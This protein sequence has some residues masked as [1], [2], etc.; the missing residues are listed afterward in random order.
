LEHSYDQVRLPLLKGISNSA[1]GVSII[2]GSSDQTA[3]KHQSRDQKQTQKGKNHPQENDSE[4]R[5]TGIGSIYK[6]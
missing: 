1:T 2:T 3:T 4:S 6:E 5:P